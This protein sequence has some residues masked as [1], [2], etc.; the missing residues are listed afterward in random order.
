MAILIYEPYKYYLWS[1][2]TLKLFL[3]VPR[4][5]HNKC[6]RVSELGRS[7][8]KAGLTVRKVFGFLIE[9]VGERERQSFV[10]VHNIPVSGGFLCV[11]AFRKYSVLF[12]GH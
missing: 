6:Y 1:F 7:L 5:L 10:S 9:T 8:F 3:H 4:L 2:L 12:K 11:C